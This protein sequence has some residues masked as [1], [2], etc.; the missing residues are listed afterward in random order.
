MA[1]AVST[2]APKGFIAALS[3]LRARI[4]RAVRRH[5]E[6]SRTL[7]ELSALTD[8]ELADLGF[9]RFDLRRLARE[10]ADRI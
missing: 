6:Y 9:S 8:R 4:D 5:V 2:A 1:Y 7:D 3:A 10:A